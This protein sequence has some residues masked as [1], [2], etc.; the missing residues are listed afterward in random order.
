MREFIHDAPARQAM[1]KNISESTDH[2]AKF[3]GHYWRENKKCAKKAGQLI[4]GYQKFVNHVST[5]RKNQQSDSKNKSFIV[6]KKMIHDPLIF[7]KLKFFEMVH[8]KLNTFL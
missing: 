6:L 7:A 3:C 5:L 1:Y 8:H 4:K 2:P